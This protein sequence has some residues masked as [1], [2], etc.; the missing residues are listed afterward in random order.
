MKKHLF[1]LFIAAAAVMGLTVSCSKD[2]EQLPEVIDSHVLDS[3]VDEQI[4]AV[5]GTDGSTSLSYTS[6]ILVNQITRSGDNRIA[7][8]VNNLLK[9]L[10]GE[11]AV[12]SFAQGQ[13]RVSTTYEQEG[14][15]REGYVTILDSVMVYTIGYEGFTIQ[16]RLQYEVPVYDD[17]VTKQIMPYYRYQNLIDHNDE[18]FTDMGYYTDGDGRIQGKKKYNHSISVDFNGNPYEVTAE[19]ILRRMLS[20]GEPCV[21]K[22]EVTD[23][24]LGEITDGRYPVWLTAKQTWSTGE[25]KTETVKADLNVTIEGHGLESIIIPDLGINFVST[26]MEIATSEGLPSDSKFLNLRLYSGKFT[27]KYNY[28]EVGFDVQYSEAV[29]DDGVT[30]CKLPGY[31]FGNISCE[32]PVTEYIG[33]T[34]ISGGIICKEYKLTQ[35]ITATIGKDNRTIYAYLTVY[36]QK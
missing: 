13:K 29:Y 27:V 22:S 15:R 32:N 34:E 3:G 2:D 14:S 23:Q 17:G 5:S 1:F 18:V 10:T 28:F 19:V 16:Y 35:G 33:E 11:V 12:A 30:V 20:S 8:K 24:G 25:E 21:V 4:Q 26:Q 6:W 9:P 7:V 31:S 36:I